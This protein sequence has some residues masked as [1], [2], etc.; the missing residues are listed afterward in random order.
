MGLNHVESIYHAR[1]PRDPQG[2]LPCE[3]IACMLRSVRAVVWP[4]SQEL[5]SAMAMIPITTGYDGCLLDYNS[6]DSLESLTVSEFWQPEHPCQRQVNT[7]LTIQE[8]G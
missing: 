5:P 4:S 6:A 2:P 7:L 1:A 8:D 3:A